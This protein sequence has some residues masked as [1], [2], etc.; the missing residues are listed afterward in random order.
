MPPAG[1]LIFKLEQTLFRVSLDY[2]EVL[3]LVSTAQPGVTGQRS[4]RGLAPAMLELKKKIGKKAYDRARVKVEAAAERVET[5]A[6]DSAQMHPGVVKMLESVRDTGWWVVAVS[7]IGRK[8]V[9]GFLKSKFLDQYMNLVLARSRLDQERPLAKSLRPVQTKLKTLAHSVYFCNSSR[10][11]VDAKT[12][13]MKCFVLP[14]QVEPFRALYQ[15]GPN[16]IILSLDEIP[17]LLSLP[18][19]KLPPPTP[20]VEKPRKGIKK[21]AS[22]ITPKTP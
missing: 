10:E 17:T 5:R 15:A 3:G 13:G 4:T 9:A 21:V 7:D 20:A 19:M 1:A 11:V 12:L 18:N 16:G 6:L 22:G 8:P 14:S 2:G